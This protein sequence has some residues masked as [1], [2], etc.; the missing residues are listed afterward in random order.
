[1]RTVPLM[2]VLEWRA[3]PPHPSSEVEWEDLLVR[4]EIAPRALRLALAQT[5]PARP[6][7][8]KTLLSALGVELLLR[9]TLESMAEG[10]EAPSSADVEGLPAEPDLLAGEI[11]RHRLR[12]FVF[13][14]RRGINVWEWRAR[15][16]F[17]DGATLYQLLGAA[18]LHD[19]RLLADLRGAR[20]GG[21]AC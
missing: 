15:G 21:G 3:F 11:E 19:A 10:G 9:G 1:M 20:G 8:A 2:P 7:V 18:M 5:D 14:Q 16:G 6:G 17:W 13:V 12:N 4:L